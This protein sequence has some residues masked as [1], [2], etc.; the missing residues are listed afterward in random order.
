MCKPVKLG[1]ILYASKNKAIMS[2]LK[3]GNRTSFTAIAAQVGCN[4]SHVSQVYRKLVEEGM[5]D[6][7]APLR[8]YA[9]GC[10]PGLKKPGRKPSVKTSTKRPRRKK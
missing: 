6:T 7:Y 5:E 1:C 4:L 8:G 3:R 10:N 2:L 9:H